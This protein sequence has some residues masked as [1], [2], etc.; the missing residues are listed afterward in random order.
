MKK[1]MFETVI[2]IAIRTISVTDTINKGDIKALKIHI[3]SDH[4]T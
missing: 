2:I 4:E 1:T 3:F